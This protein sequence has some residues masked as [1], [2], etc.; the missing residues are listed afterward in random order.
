MLFYY[1]FNTPKSGRLSSIKFAVI[2]YAKKLLP[3]SYSIQFKNPSLIVLPASFV[4]LFLKSL[5]CPD[6]SNPGYLIQ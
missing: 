4:S 5:S 3:D 2:L 1:P 6:K